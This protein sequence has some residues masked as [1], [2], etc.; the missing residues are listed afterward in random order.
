MRKSASPCVIAALKCCRRAVENIRDLFDPDAALCSAEP[1]ANGVLNAELL[2]TTVSMDFAWLVEARSSEIVNEIVKLFSTDG[3]TW[4]QAFDLRTELRDHDATGLIIEHIQKFDVEPDL[5]NEFRELRDKR[6]EECRDALGR[7][8]KETRN[9]IDKAVTFG[10]LKESELTALIARLEK[11]ELVFGSIARFAPAHE[12]LRSI[13]DE[14]IGKREAQVAEV[15]AR[16]T[17]SKLREDVCNRV[18]AV[19]ATGDVLS[20]NGI[21]TSLEVVARCRWRLTNRTRLHNFSQ[22]LTGTLR[23]FWSHR[24]VGADRNPECLLV[25]FER[26]QRVVEK[27]SR[28]V[29]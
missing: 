18:L 7:D 29:R 28:L 4:K 19:L 20:A 24:M 14:I 11:V 1:V 2:Y 26:W 10:L 15:R 27:E 5:V 23:R 25:D 3:L 16:L 12:E 17:A 8:L 13:R 6:L 9:E 22:N 21:S